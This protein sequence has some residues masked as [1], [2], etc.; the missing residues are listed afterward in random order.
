MEEHTFLFGV[1]LLDELIQN[2]LNVR[3]ELG[4]YFKVDESVTEFSVSGISHLVEVLGL[5]ELLLLSV[6]DLV[7]KV[8]TE[9]IGRL[10]VIAIG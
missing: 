3:I 4:R 2:V 1:A 5:L 7:C 9:R 8:F 10:V 6:E